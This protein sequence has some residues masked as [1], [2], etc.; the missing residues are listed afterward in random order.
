[1]DKF[2][3]MGDELTTYAVGIPSISSQSIEVKGETGDNLHPLSNSWLGEAKKPA[4]T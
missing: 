1:M 4:R 2:E 3:L